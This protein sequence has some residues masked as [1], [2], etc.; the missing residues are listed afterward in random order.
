M[1]SSHQVALAVL[2][3]VRGV[4]PA[5][6]DSDSFYCTGKGYIAFDLRSFIHPD[7]KAPHVLRFFRFNAERGIY[8]A[9][10]WPMKDFQIHGMWCS[11]SRI[12]VA[13][14]ENAR[15]VFDIADHESRSSS[16]SDD[17]GAS[18]GEGQLG[19]SVAGVKPLESSDPR[20][21]N[22]STNWSFQIQ[23]KTPKS[24]VRRSSFKSTPT[25][26]YPSECSCTTV[27]TQRQ[28]TRSLS[29]QLSQTGV[30]TP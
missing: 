27:G 2:L 5:F 14:S 4:A 13:G 1:K 20:I 24:L 8:K 23:R 19:W 30:S 29:A 25:K 6:A 11:D 21:Q 10:E 3:C 15:Y 9:S 16:A 26:T 17:D 28:P 18:S 22:T 12:V 7:L